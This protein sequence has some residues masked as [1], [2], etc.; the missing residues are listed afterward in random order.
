MSTRL[1]YILKGN[2]GATYILNT[3]SWKNI[4]ASLKFYRA[5][6]LK[7]H[8]LKQGLHW[9]LLF[10]WILFKR[11]LKSAIEINQY[12]QKVSVTKTNF[13][14]NEYCSVLISPTYDKVIVNHHHEYFQKFAFEKSYHNV[15][16]EATIYALITKSNKYFQTSNYYDVEDKKDQLISFKLSNTHVLTS[17]E[18]TTTDGLTLALVEFFKATASGKCTIKTYIEH[19]Q[20]ELQ[21]LQEIQTET[22]EQVLNVIKKN[23]GELEFPLGLV[24]RDFKPW[25]VINYSKPLIFDFEEAITDGPPLEDLLNYYIDPIIRYKTTEEV[26]KLALNETQILNY[27]NYL[28][29]LNIEIE[30]KVFLHF[31]L[32]ERMLFWKNT[33]EVETAMSYR[34]LS[35]HLILQEK[36]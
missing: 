28:Q 12:L 15:K 7:A 19:L 1:F 20:S 33:N 11:K 6:T 24:H 26:I 18:K 2:N 22:Q 16:K 10:K 9:Y 21:Q 27:K 8:I 23:Y 13:N 30:F 3:S 31:Y 32:I 34:K 35:N 25:N 4:G 17:T 14:I 36:L 5:R 29:E